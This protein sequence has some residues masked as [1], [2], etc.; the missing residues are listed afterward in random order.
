MFNFEKFVNSSLFR[1][2]DL[3][4]KIIII[5][6]MIVVSLLP[7]ITFI[8]A[9]VAGYELINYYIDDNEAPLVKS[10]IKA[11]KK[12]FL[13]HIKIELILA[14][15]VTL[16]VI[17]FKTY[18]SEI[19]SGQMYVVGLYVTLVIMFFVSLM[20]INVPLSCV[21]F[22]NLNAL[23]ILKIS[24]YIGIKHVFTSILLLIPVALSAA[25]LNFVF[26]IFTFIGVGIPIF[27]SLK[28]SLPIYKKLVV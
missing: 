23:R 17:N 22:P 2:A 19:A 5:N 14:V 28:L 24:F 7:I 9:L 15:I 27:I 11:F 6:L 21:F 12:N 20:V 4:F 18:Y 13:R 1:Y 8:P 3:L 16:L 26:P 25:L 10:F